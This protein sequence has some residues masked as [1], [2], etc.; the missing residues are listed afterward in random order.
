MQS[1]RIRK[2]EICTKYVEL[3]SSITCH[4]NPEDEV[5]EL[6]NDSHRNL[7]VTICH[8]FHAVTG[9]DDGGGRTYIDGGMRI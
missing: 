7:N 1:V 2:A 5:L 4:H 8:W 9:T 3:L 6:H